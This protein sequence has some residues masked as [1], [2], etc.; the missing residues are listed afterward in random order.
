MLSK[1]KEFVIIFT[2]GTAFGIIL[3]VI[4]YMMLH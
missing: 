1:G 4:F 3:S 2:M